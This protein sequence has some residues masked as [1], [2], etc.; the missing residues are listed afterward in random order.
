LTIYQDQENPLSAEEIQAA[1]PRV[2]DCMDCHNRPSHQY[3]SPERAID[4]AILTGRIDRSLPAIKRV[5]VEA[6]AK[7]YE[8]E[9]DARRSIATLVPDYYRTNHP[10]ILAEKRVAIDQAVVAIQEQFSQIIFPEMKVRWDGYPDNIGH[11]IYPGCMRC[12]DGNKVSD[13][14]WVVTR[15][16]R[17]CHI[18]LSQGS[19]DRAQ[20]AASPDGLEFVHPED[21]EDEWRETGCYDCHTGTQP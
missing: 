1:V 16:C 11:L 4:S 21:I 9:D 15:E 3:R 14:G 13:D 19:G 7:T 17:T 20:M 12:H 5:A 10:E 2:M 18:I 6:M 8:T